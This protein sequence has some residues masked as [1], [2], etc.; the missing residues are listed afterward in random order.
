MFPLQAA[1]TP[2]SRLF[3]WRISPPAT[4]G[5][6]IS[7]MAMDPNG[8]L[9]KVDD[10]ILLVNPQD[11]YQKVMPATTVMAPDGTYR[12]DVFPYPVSVIQV[13][14]LERGEAILGMAKRYFAA[15]GT[16]TD[17]RIEFSDH[18]KFLEDKRVYIIKAYANGMPKGRQRVPTSGHLWYDAARLQGD[19]GGRPRRL[20]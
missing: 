2:K 3:P 5:Q 11:Y 10:L 9:R 17:G 7:L 20:H 16:S 14:A 6:L 15:A 8:K 4:M 13:P 1:F 12:N 18:V 19:P